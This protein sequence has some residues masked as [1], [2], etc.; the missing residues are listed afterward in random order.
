MYEFLKWILCV[1]LFVHWKAIRLISLPFFDSLTYLLVL[2]YL[3][4]NNRKEPATN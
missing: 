2:F 1:C 3:G 4:T